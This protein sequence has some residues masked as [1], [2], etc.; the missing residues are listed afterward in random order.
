MAKRVMRTSRLGPTGAGLLVLSGPQMP[1]QF[2]LTMASAN[3][4]FIALLPV[5]DHGREVDFRLSSDLGAHWPPSASPSA[6]FWS[7]RKGTAKLVGAD[8]E[9]LKNW[10]TGR[11]VPRAS[12][13]PAIIRLLGYDPLP[14]PTTQGEAVQNARLRRG[15]SR[16]RLAKAS[17]V[18]E[19]TVARIERDTPRLARRPVDYV[20][21]TLKLGRT[22][23]AAGSVSRHTQVNARQNSVAISRGWSRRRLGREAGGTR[24]RSAG[25]KP[26]CQAWLANHSSAFSLR[27]G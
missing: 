1:S 14:V 25:S 3:H 5:V 9:S 4:C 27:S 21:R 15:W 22:P 12:F 24:Q 23:R 2:A 26:T 7:H 19:A 16:K 18:D 10:E 13:Y 8:E 6:G 20:R 11:C 17:G